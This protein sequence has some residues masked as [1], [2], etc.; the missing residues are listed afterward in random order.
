MRDKK[1]LKEQELV[2]QK[3][4]HLQEE[5]AKT[6]TGDKFIQTFRGDTL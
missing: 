2:D 3:K 6:G 4:R 5:F 1:H